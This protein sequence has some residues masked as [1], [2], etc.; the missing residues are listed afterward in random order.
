M[1][2]SENAESPSAPRTEPARG[3][4]DA[5]LS[6]SHADGA[7]AR[8]LHH[9]VQ[10]IGTRFRDARHLRVF[11]DE[12]TAAAT[13]DLWSTIARA[14]ADSRHFVL[15]ASPTAARSDWV[16]RELD[17]WLAR[18]F[19][20]GTPE[21]RMVF[22]VTA[23]EVRW[24]RT[25]GT[26][27]WERTDALPRVLD[28]SLLGAD[29]PPRDLARRPWPEPLLIDLTW[30][31]EPRAR[32]R[33]R[34]DLVD[35]AARIAAF[36]EGVDKDVVLARELVLQ[37]RRLTLLYG[38]L[39]LLAILAAGL[40]LAIGELTSQRNAASAAQIR[41]EASLADGLAISARRAID[42][43]RHRAAR[44]LVRA[45]RELSD[46]PLAHAEALRVQ[47]SMLRFEGAAAHSE[48]VTEM[49][50]STDGSWTLTSSGS[51]LALWHEDVVRLR[52]ESVYLHPSTGSSA[53]FHPTR[54]ELVI[55]STD[56]TLWWLT[57]DESLTAEAPPAPALTDVGYVR[58]LWWAGD[59]EVHAVLDGGAIARYGREG[60]RGRA[61]GV[62]HPVL[63]QR[64][65][66]ADL[67]VDA[68]TGGRVELRRGDA[69][70][71]IDVNEHLP[72]DAGLAVQH[73][74]P[75]LDAA[76]RF[77]LVEP[78]A[79]PGVPPVLVFDVS[80]APRRIAVDG[81]LPELPADRP[82][83]A[84]LVGTSTVAVPGTNEIALV[85][86][87]AE[88][89][90]AASVRRLRLDE[91]M[92]A[93]ATHPL[94]PMIGVGRRDGRVALL[95]ASDVDDALIELV[96]AVDGA[97]DAL[98]WS[99]DGRV[100]TIGGAGQLRRYSLAPASSMGVLETGLLTGV[101][102][103]R[104][105]PLAV[106]AAPFLSSAPVVGVLD[107][108]D[109]GLWL[110][111]DEGLRAK[112]APKLAGAAL[113]DDGGYVLYARRNGEVAGWELASPDRSAYGWTS[114][115]AAVERV[116]EVRRASRFVLETDVEVVVLDAASGDVLARHPREPG[117]FVFAAAGLDPELARPVSDLAER[118]YDVWSL[119]DDELLIVT[120][121]EAVLVRDGERSGHIPLPTTRFVEAVD[122]DVE[123]R[124][125]LRVAQTH[126][127]TFTHLEL[128]SIDSGEAFVAWNPS[129]ALYSR[130]GVGGGITGL[131]AA[132]LSDGGA[133][134]ISGYAVFQWWGLGL[135]LEDDHPSGL[136]VVGTDVRPTSPGKPAAAGR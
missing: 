10:T 92:T 117:A 134:S 56:G 55:G 82:H 83:C 106:F 42:D 60:E 130:E 135:G 40:V 17:H 119:G 35:A 110:P 13:A 23:G 41:A 45:A 81:A 67:T 100:L 7:L 61:D 90:E 52:I 85:D 94:A 49:D 108:I 65:A 25:L 29:E 51:D 4:F 121:D 118:A 53:A 18:E 68:M 129:E 125:L 71:T 28:H 12:A 103:A 89:S 80:G 15:L 109:P 43:R 70:H 39:A 34:E 88:P 102:P 101:R 93:W 96:D 73:V 26:F 126:R 14:L 112:D 115:G 20:E 136:E 16:K 62:P 37:R 50:C 9:R 76:G 127:Q 105:T 74:T 120:G 77:L 84:F 27:D 78:L 107:P 131:R 66:T 116:R 2:R 36:V 97:A 87:P 124:R 122:V 6:Y 1:S 44:E 91:P 8:A 128:V 24:S 22:A 86:L 30:F 64:I 58:N 33:R 11:R 31:R 21:G 59:D 79:D 111:D 69:V 38:G 57:L 46:T 114:V 75:T 19:D 95:D 133:L 72:A 104:D 123:R 99:A 47:P 5:F 3:R 63:E 98:V 48:R 132:R 32:R 113:V 54:P